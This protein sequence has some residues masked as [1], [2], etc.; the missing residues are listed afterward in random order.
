[1]NLEVRV[2]PGAKKREMKRDDQ[3]I[4]VKLLSRP[5]EGKANREL[6]EYLASEFSV[7][8]S[9]IRIVAGEKGRKKII[10]LPVDQEQFH[11]VIEALEC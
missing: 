4:V 6:I 7:R 5:Q 11:A 8:K 10:S 3:G 1:M 2:I 9:E